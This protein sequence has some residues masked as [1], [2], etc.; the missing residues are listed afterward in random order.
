MTFDDDFIQLEFAGGARRIA[1]KSM[2]VTWPP[3]ARLDVAGFPFV[4]E[5]YSLITAEQR[6]EMDFL[7]RG[8]RYVPETSPPLMTREQEGLEAFERG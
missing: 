2:G 8:A 1:C 3:P 6:K 5:T 7:A 4:R